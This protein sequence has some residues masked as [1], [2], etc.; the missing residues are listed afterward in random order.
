MF[1]QITQVTRHRHEWLRFERRLSGSGWEEE[2]EG[3]RT[4]WLEIWLVKKEWR[5]Q[6]TSLYAEMEETAKSCI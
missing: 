3:W 5:R 6:E 2:E 1:Y 4:C